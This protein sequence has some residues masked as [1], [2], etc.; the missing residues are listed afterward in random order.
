MSTARD[1]GRTP[2][3]ARVGRARPA[4]DFDYAPVPRASATADDDGGPCDVIVATARAVDLGVLE[5]TVGALLASDDL[6]IDVVLARAPLFWVRVRS[7]GPLRRDDLVH[8][9]V[10]ADVPVRYVAST[11][12]G[13]LALPEPL[14]LDGAADAAPTTWR[15]R[16]ATR[17]HRATRPS[18]GPASERRASDG[19]WFLDAAGG[20]AID[21]AHCGVGAGTRLAVIDDDAADV[22]HLD[23]DALVL[24]GV[25]RVP[26]SS[27]H[28]SLMV[29]WAAAARRSLT[30]PDARFVGVAPDTSPRLYCI[31]KPDID[32]VSLALAVARAVLDGADVVVCATY[33]EGA[34]SPML[35]DA[36]EVAARL[37]R[38]GRGTPVLFPTGRE[39]SSPAGSMHASLSLSLGDPASDP[40]ATC[41]APGGRDGGWFVWKD[42]SGKYRPFANRG[43]AVRFVAP[44]D[45]IAYPFTMRARLFHAESSGASAVAAGVLLLVLGTNPTL[46][47][48]E[49]DA[50]LARTVDVDRDDH[51]RRLRAL[52][53]A[54]P[55]D[56]LPRGTDADG[57][58][59][60]QGYGHLH[61]TRACLAASD[62]LAFALV[63]MGEVPA[64]ARVA[65]A[66][67]S[68]A[69]R[70]HG[71][72]RLY[73]PR[74]ARWA[75]R[76][77]LGDP[78]ADHALRVVMRH[79]RLVAH[80]LA[81]ADAQPRDALL[82][83][84]ALTLRGLIYSPVGRR[85]PAV[86]AKELGAYARVLAA[87]TRTGDAQLESLFT[88]GLTAIFG[89]TDTHA[90]HRVAHDGAPA[91]PRADN[92]PHRS[93]A[94]G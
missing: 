74:A 16:G 52:A 69:P 55:A 87:A 22:E 53:L 13:S 54:D 36:L 64:A 86:V 60:K 73:S 37:G 48:S 62:P 6:A 44:G 84:L 8:A 40:R 68:P 46:T 4:W 17:A 10:D 65:E 72:A 9:L 39:T 38:R 21:R 43:P 83:Q 11:L 63:A 1:A 23:L 77:L 30:V 51:E 70:N 20:V 88:T 93:P 89:A 90:A 15:R 12:R 81:R 66:L 34:M 78:R 35:D 3:V 42:K 26:R 56:V 57:H 76:A 92:P 18:D 58:D 24:V 33:V 50:I 25:D 67:A 2:G 31:P 85:I 49:L 75:V 41:I 19:L 61:A 14:E 91:A 5:A 59:A 94:F 71:R 7:P 79:A 82:R 27:S 45:D 32:V 80:Q 29:A 28:G 47:A